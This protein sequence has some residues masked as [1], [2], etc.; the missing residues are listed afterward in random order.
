MEHRNASNHHEPWN[1]GKLGMTNYPFRSI[2]DF[3]D[4]EVK[5]V[6]RRLVEAGKVSAT[7]YLDHLR[8][9]S[10]DNAGTPMQWSTAE[11]GGLTTG[12]PWFAVN[13]NYKEI[14]AASQIDDPASVYNHHRRLL[15]LRRQTP[16]LVYG[17]YRDVD[18]EHEKVFAYLRTLWDVSFLVLINFSRKRIDYA[19]PGL[20]VGATVLDN[21]A[22]ETA[23]VGSATV[24]LAPWQATIYSTI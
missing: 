13:P 5:G 11:N 23:R 7:E 2:E 6:W 24:S 9:T 18:P 20:K 14:N 8:H 10:R 16:A 22:G 3:D 21:G 17:E 19:L 12:K 1:K 15:A 4:V